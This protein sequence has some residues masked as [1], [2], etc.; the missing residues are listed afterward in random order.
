VESVCLYIY[1]NNETQRINICFSNNSQIRAHFSR[2]CPVPSCNLRYI[3]YPFLSNPVHKYPTIYETNER[4][5]Y[6]WSSTFIGLCLQYWSVFPV[7]A[8]WLL[9]IDLWHPNWIAARNH[10]SDP[11]RLS[12]LQRACSQAIPAIAPVTINFADSYWILS[13]KIAITNKQELIYW[14]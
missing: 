5:Q 13:S 1:F 11:C 3:I 8:D 7:C 2:T 10:H 12:F 6:K 14:F 4:I 9:L